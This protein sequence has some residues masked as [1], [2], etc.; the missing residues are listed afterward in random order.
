VIPLGGERLIK[1]PITTAT[2]LFIFR[3]YQHIVN[4]LSDTTGGVISP[5]VASKKIFFAKWLWWQSLH[6]KQLH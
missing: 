5:M 3:H 6:F 4:P 1:K 2:D